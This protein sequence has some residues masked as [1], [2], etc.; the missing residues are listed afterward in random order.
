MSDSVV[1]H[2]DSNGNGNG[3]LTKF[4]K[5]S[6]LLFIA[7]GIGGGYFSSQIT[8]SVQSARQD[9]AIVQ[10]QA[11]QSKLV[12]DLEDLRNNVVPRSEHQATLREQETLDHWVEKYNDAM[13]AHLQHQI[14]DLETRARSRQ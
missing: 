1:H 9:Q 4:S 8:S 7:V 13:N 11:V 6:P 3:A 10:L 14:D 12:T 5:L 2:A